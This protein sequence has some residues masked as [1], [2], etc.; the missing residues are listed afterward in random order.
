MD[1]RG[2]TS[3]VLLLGLAWSTAGA[4]AGLLPGA[5]TTS[6]F[7]AFPP[8]PPT[9]AFFEDGGWLVFS[10]PV[11]GDV[12]YACPPLEGQSP[13]CESVILP[14]R[15]PG[16]TLQR[17]F[18]DPDTGAAWFKTSVPPMGDYL[19]ACYDPGGSPY[20]KLAIIEDRPGGATLARLGVGSEGAD[21]GL[22]ALPTSGTTAAPAD[23]QPEQ[24]SAEFWMT[25]ALPAPGPV[26]LYACGALEKEPGCRVAV[27]GL[28]L[29]DAEDFGI[30]KLAASSSGVVVEGV[31]GG[32]VADRAGL[33]EGDVITA[34]AGFELLSPAHLKGL[35]AQVPVGGTIR[36]EVEGSGLIKM[37]R[38]ARD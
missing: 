35:L 38:R 27:A 8:A 2:I 14:I 34:A 18:V 33:R 9:P 36:L 24:N 20:C 6:D 19:L 16:S 7:E 23:N 17:W 12:L 32:S 21:S 13:T 28:S 30:Q 11:I 31:K 10:V 1:S 5:S 37:T 3:V 4:A 26:T 29:V 22:L 25:A 15:G